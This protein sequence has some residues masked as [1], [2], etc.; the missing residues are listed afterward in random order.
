MMTVFGV[1]LS[2]YSGESPD[3]FTDIQD[4]QL[5]ST[6]WI[7]CICMNINPESSTEIIGNKENEFVCPECKSLQTENTFLISKALRCFLIV[8]LDQ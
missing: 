8:Y 3:I 7:H 5:E 1:I 4:K 2:G 6:L